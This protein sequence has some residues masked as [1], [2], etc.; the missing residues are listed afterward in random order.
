MNELAVVESQ[1]DVAIVEL[2]PRE[3]VEK[4][5]EMAVVLQDVVK[6]GGLSTSFGGKKE[7]IFY[8]GW[9]TLGE[10][11]NCSAVVE[12]TKSMWHNDKIIGWEARANI[13]NS[14]G[15]IVSSCEAMC[16]KD[17]KN[18]KDRDSYALRSMAQTRACSKAFR[19]KFSWVAVL[20]GYSATPAEE[21][22]F[23]F[24]QEES[25][26]KKAMGKKKEQ[27]K[28]K[29]TFQETVG[30]MLEEIFRLG[31]HD[32]REGIYGS[33][34]IQGLDEL[35]DKKNQEEFYKTVLADL[36]RF[37]E[38]GTKSKEIDKDGS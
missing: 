33:Y 21:M 3:Q 4:A 19:Q 24:V 6:Q 31:H 5:S 29:P 18:W 38:E 10:F 25:A 23:D 7:H 2:T 20:A 22:S 27:A 11:F 16:A 17:E 12:W 15:Q 32:Y 37:R 35:T 8:E 13:V 34:Q 26:R 36:A 1:G 28:P 30:P 9:Q 14:Q